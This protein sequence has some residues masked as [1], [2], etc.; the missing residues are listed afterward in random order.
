MMLEQKMDLIRV[1]IGP[2]NFYKTQ[3]ARKL[4]AGTAS[5]GT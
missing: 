4:I 1:S 3:A 2:R 5:Q